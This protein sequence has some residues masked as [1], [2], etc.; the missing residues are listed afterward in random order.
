MLRLL[1]TLLLSAAAMVV[2]DLLFRTSLLQQ[3]RPVILSPTDQA[4]VAP[5]VQLR[6]DGPPRMRVFLSVAG[7]ARRDLGVHEA[8]FDIDA[9]QFPRDGGYLVELQ[10]VRLGNWIHTQRWFQVH[11]SPATASRADDHAE[12]GGTEVKDLLRALE[13]TRTARDRAHGRT[14]FLSEE[15]AALRDE[16]ERLS[17]QLEALYKTQEDDAEQV[18]EL[19]RRL[20]QLSEENRA[21][22]EENAAVRLRLGSVIPCTVWGYFSYPRPQMAPATRRFLMVSDG[23]GQIFRTQPDC[24]LL[25]RS[26]ATAASICFCV[27]NSWGG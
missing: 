26:D 17:K 20:S 23:R 13:A 25:R 21:L 6:W 2:G 5:P 4:V 24:E 15:N 22:A 10:A 7:E 19:E 18:A 3:V 16:S 14:K 11:A 9:D 1:A 12:R 27:G 8:P